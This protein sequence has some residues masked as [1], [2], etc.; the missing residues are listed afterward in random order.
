[1]KLYTVTDG[2]RGPE[3]FAAEVEKET[4]KLYILEVATRAFGYV[5]HVGK[6][7]LKKICASTNP[8]EA[9]ALWRQRIAHEIEDAEKAL[10]DL[11]RRSKHVFEGFDC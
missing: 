8:E 3:L 9:I 4:A 11:I 5:R 10:H 2:R 1:M 6:F 7:R